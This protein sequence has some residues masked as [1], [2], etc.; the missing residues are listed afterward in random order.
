MNLKKVTAIF[1]AAAASMTLVSCNRG[2]GKETDP[3][4]TTAQTE[5]LYDASTEAMKT[6]NLTVTKGELTYIAYY[7][8][9]Q[10]FNN[11]APYLS[12]YGLDVS[13][14]LKN[15]KCSFEGHDTWYDY[16][17]DSTLSYAS[18]TLSACEAA[19][20]TGYSLSDEEKAEI[21]KALSGWQNTASEAGCAD[22]DEYIR[23]KIR[24]DFT[25]ADI[26]SYTEKSYLSSKYFSDVLDSYEIT[27]DEINAL[28]AADE[29][30]FKYI[31]F[32]AYSFYAENGAEGDAAARAENLAQCTNKNA[33]I[34]YVKG[35]LN[36]VILKSISDDE[37]P[38]RI[39]SIMDTVIN[40]LT[41]KGSGEFYDW[42]FSQTGDGMTD[43]E[44]SGLI[45]TVNNEESGSYTVYLLTRAPYRV[46]TPVR[47][48]RDIKLTKATCETYSGAV[49]KAEELLATFD[50]TEDSFAALAR[51]WSED[52]DSRSSGGIVKNAATGETVPV[53]IDPWL[54]SED[55]APGDTEIIKADGECHLVYYV[56]EGLPKWQS[57][58]REK[59][60]YARYTEDVKKIAETYPV[61][62][63]VEV[64]ADVE[65]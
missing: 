46:D 62:R 57:D 16:F 13:K 63:S 3:A 54:F 27:E 35:Y 40:E 21:D 31:D 14:P 42:A 1:L 49:A 9:Q 32:L 5:P 11:Y 64:I 39:A 24:H 37:K 58:A 25:L 4:D 65:V 53:E 20:A 50:G 7:N 26:R 19:M 36:E 34:D 17:M 38:S 33:F 8:Y 52:A 22:A 12:Y 45:Y 47:T 44:G 59:L 23:T 51:E 2:N 61:T 56:S 55:R 60:H 29:N 15:Q 43:E 28:Y 6:E 41:S 48:Y 30:S 10:F 18:Q